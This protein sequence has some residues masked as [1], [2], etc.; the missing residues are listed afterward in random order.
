MSLLHRPRWRLVGR[1]LCRS[2]FSNACPR[3]AAAC[4]TIRRVIRSASFATILSHPI[5]LLRFQLRHGTCDGPNL[6]PGTKSKSHAAAGLLR[7]RVKNRRRTGNSLPAGQRNKPTSY[8]LQLGRAWP[9]RNG[10]HPTASRSWSGCWPPM[11]HPTATSFGVPSSGFMKKRA[12]IS[13][14]LFLESELRR[15][16]GALKLSAKL[17]SRRRPPSK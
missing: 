5:C 3:F 8:S 9:R 13:I 12:T 15:K 17:F 11:G 6:M 1:S 4:R 7:Q 10:L 2:T 14:A 16:L